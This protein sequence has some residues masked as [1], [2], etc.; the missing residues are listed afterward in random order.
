MYWNLSRKATRT[1][2]K[3]QRDNALS[4]RLKTL[5]EQYPLYGYLMLRALLVREGLVVNKKR[6]YRLYKAM[7]MQVLTKRRR[8]L[9]RPRVPM[10]SIVT[11][12]WKYS[13]MAGLLVRASIDRKATQ[14]RL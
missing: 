6:T 1:P 4:A 7:G 9:I 10:V 5:G 14:F 8:K 12:N 3:S 13:L 2:D 11:I